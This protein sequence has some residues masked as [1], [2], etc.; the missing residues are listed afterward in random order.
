M[1]A[2]DLGNTVDCWTAAMPPLDHL[3]WRLYKLRVPKEP[4]TFWYLVGS[5]R[6]VI[7]GTSANPKYEQNHFPTSNKKSYDTCMQRSYIDF[8][9]MLHPNDMLLTIRLPIH[10]HQAGR[11]LWWSSSCWF[12]PTTVRRRIRHA[13]KTKTKKYMCYFM[14]DVQKNGMVWA[15]NQ[16]KSL[17]NCWYSGGISKSSLTLVTKVP[18]SPDSARRFSGWN[19]LQALVTSPKQWSLHSILRIA[20]TWLITASQR[21]ESQISWTWHTHRGLRF[22]L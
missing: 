15:C 3:L 5:N 18:P 13:C 16:H 9:S 4:W 22:L 19:T 14:D 21:I 17:N 8:S 20:L 6:F 2:S 10:Q 12:G 11:N 7:H 1:H